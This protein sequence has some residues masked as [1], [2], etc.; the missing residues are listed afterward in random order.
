MTYNPATNYV[1]DETKLELLKSSWGTDQS[2]SDIAT[3]LGTNDN[4]VRGKARRL[5]LK[6]KRTLY[7]PKVKKV[8]VERF[9]SDGRPSL[10]RRDPLLEA[11]INAHGPEMSHGQEEKAA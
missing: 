11:L 2:L 5:G 1:W 9:Y 6:R 7:P 3:A 10:Q 8:V 4:V